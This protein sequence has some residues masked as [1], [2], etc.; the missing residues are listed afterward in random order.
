M[1]GEESRENSKEER[2]L[3]ERQLAQIKQMLRIA[4]DDAAYQRMMN[5]AMANKEL[6]LIASQNILVIFKRSGRKLTDSEVLSVLRAL[7]ARTQRET[8]ITFYKK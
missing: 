5:V 8:K 1:S 2:E 6:F 7:K 3:A 4:L